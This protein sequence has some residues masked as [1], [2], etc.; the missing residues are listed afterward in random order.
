PEAVIDGFL[1]Q[2]MVSGTEVLVGA[3]EDA[4]Y[5]PLL[6]LGTGGVMVELIG[7]V[8]LR[9]LPVSGDDVRAMIEGLK[10]G[11]LLAGFRG[12]PPGDTDALVDACLALGQFYLD[13]RPWLADIEI[14]PL[15][16]R[17]RGQGVCAV[18]VRAVRRG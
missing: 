1:V 9:L 14:N 10:L 18:D 6:V 8:A 12:A 5:G 4:L 17:P 16:V 7:D 13:H 2:E 11:T 3:R 15:M